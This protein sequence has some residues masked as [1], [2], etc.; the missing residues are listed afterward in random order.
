MGG[1]SDGFED[2]KHRNDNGMWLSKI[3]MKL[4]MLGSL[5]FFLI[6]FIQYNAIL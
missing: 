5:R 3:K 4:I 1:T 6:F 2:F